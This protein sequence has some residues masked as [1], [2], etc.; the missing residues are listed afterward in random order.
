MAK[1]KRPDEPGVVE[2]P[3][4][5]YQTSV[6]GLHKDIRIAGTF[7]GSV[8]ALVSPVTV[9]RLPPSKSKNRK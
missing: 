6:V 8:G 5:S 4:Q 3:E 7:V 2:N 1:P 9:R